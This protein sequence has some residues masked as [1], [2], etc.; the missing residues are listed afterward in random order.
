MCMC[1][2]KPCIKIQSIDIHPL[3]QPNMLFFFANRG[4]L[5]SC[6]LLHLSVENY[7]TQGQVVILQCCVGH[8]K[9]QAKEGED[10]RRELGTFSPGR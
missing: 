4:P 7:P 6:V 8:Y 2:F 5:S 1:H 3:L 10:K 9:M